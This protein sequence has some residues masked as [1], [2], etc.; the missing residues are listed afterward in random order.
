MHSPQASGTIISFVFAVGRLIV[1]DA[2]ELSVLHNHGGIP[3]NGVEIFF[4]KAVAGLRRGKDLAGE[5]YGDMRIGVG[6]AFIVGESFVDADH[7]FGDVVEPGELRIVDNE[8]EKLTGRDGAMIFFVATALHLEQRFVKPE[9]RLAKRY[10][11]LT[12]RS[13]SRVSLI[14]IWIVRLGQVALP[15]KRIPGFL[16]C[17]ASFG[18]YH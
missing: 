9:E 4:L 10:E 11:F 16:F 2:G 12:S 7:E 1:E 17:R 13:V 18:L 8:A 3:L 6:D 5:S 15:R 14:G